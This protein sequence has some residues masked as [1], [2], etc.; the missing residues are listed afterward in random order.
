MEMMPDSSDAAK[1]RLHAKSEMVLSS[2]CE[3]KLTLFSKRGILNKS[4]FGRTGVK[5][6]ERTLFS[7]SLVGYE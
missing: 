4:S 2:L 1:V 7:F 6:R 5:H 3:Q